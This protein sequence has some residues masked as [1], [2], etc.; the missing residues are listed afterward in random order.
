MKW[1]LSNAEQKRISFLK[2]ILFS[3]K[4]GNGFRSSI[5]KAA[6]SERDT[7]WKP[8]W[9]KILSDVVFSQQIIEHSGDD[10]DELTESLIKI[11][12]SSARQIDRLQLILTYRQSQFDFRRKSGQILMQMRIQAMI[13]FG[14]HFAMTLFMIWQFGWHEYRWIYLT[15][16]LFTCTGAFA[17]LGL[18]KKKT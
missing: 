6:D 4:N 9:E 7:F 16:A 12:S 14:L 3:M 5:E 17:L 15:S 10:S 1:K 18:G 2:R 8:R 13:L 11:D